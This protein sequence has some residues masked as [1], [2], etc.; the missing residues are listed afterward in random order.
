MCCDR[1]S[2]WRPASTA[3]PAT[4]WPGCNPIGYENAAKIAHHARAHGL[5]LRQAALATGLVDAATF[6]RVVRPATM[7]GG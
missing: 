7:V 5:T 2:C 3:L 1:S 4:R 6:D